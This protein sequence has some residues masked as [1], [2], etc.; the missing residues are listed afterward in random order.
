MAEYDD[1]DY[2]AEPVSDPEKLA[3]ATHMLMTSPPGQFWDVL[4][5]Q[6]VRAQDGEGSA[7]YNGWGRNLFLTISMAWVLVILLDL[8][9]FLRDESPEFAF[10]FKRGADRGACVRRTIRKS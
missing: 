1:G 3:I 5:G 2:A 10:G 8:V 6:T 4:T 7:P 9:V